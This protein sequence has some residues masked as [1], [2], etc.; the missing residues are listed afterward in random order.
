VV[1]VFG[2]DIDLLPFI[3]KEEAAKRGVA[4]FTWRNQYM[5]CIEEIVSGINMYH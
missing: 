2:M 3:K 5:I 4:Y 1:E